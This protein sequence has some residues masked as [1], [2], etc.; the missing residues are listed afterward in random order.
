MSQPIKNLALHLPPRDEQKG[1][2][3]VL[4]F[5]PSPLCSGAMKQV[6]DYIECL[7]LPF[8]FFLSFLFFSPFV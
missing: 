4:Q 3:R 5:K 6:N 7:V 8:F 1:F 2:T